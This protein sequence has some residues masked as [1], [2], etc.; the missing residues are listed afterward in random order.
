MIELA[1]SSGRIFFAPWHFTNSKYLYL[2]VNSGDDGV[3]T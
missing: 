1:R 3:N 2:F